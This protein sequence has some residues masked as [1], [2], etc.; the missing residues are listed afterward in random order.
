MIVRRKG[1]LTEF[2]PSPQEKREGLIRD[3]ILALVESL[4]R[5]IERLERVS[6]LPTKKSEAF[7]ELLRRIRTD[8]NQN[9]ELHN[10][11][12]TGGSVDT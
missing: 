6:G 4:H 5:R 12:I 10:S 2:I 1:G 7:A 8:E 3:H 11:I 9:L